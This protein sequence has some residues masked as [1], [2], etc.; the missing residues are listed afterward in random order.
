MR[1]FQRNDESIKLVRLT[2]EFWDLRK[3]LDFGC[4]NDLQKKRQIEKLKKIVEKIKLLNW[5]QE[6]EILEQ[7]YF[8]SKT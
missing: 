4:Y 1:D 7:I 3:G 2:E 5:E 8:T 6:F